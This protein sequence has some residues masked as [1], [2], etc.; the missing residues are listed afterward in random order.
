[1]LFSLL[2]PFGGFYSGTRRSLFDAFLRSLLNAVI[3]CLAKGLNT[4]SMRLM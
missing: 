3:Q 1:M 2:S 4:L